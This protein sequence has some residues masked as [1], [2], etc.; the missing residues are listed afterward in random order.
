MCSEEVLFLQH[1]AFM[2][3]ENLYTVLLQKSYDCK[4]NV[5]L[6][7]DSVTRFGKCLTIG[8]HFTNVLILFKS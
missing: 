8:K 2:V 5:K 3:S 7:V 6:V 1:F 4:K